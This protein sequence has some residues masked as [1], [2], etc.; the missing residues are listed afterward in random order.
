MQFIEGEI[1]HVYNRGNNNQPIF[2]NRDNYLFFLFKIRKELTPY[3]DIIAYCL[4]PNHF[5]LI[6]S[7]K[8]LE[9]AHRMTSSHPMSKTSMSKNFSTGLAILLRSYTRAL[10]N[11]QHFTGSLFQ[12]KT[13]ARLIENKTCNFTINDLLICMNYVHQNPLKARLVESM[14]AWE[15][16]SYRD[17]ANLRSGTLCNKQLGFELTGLDECEFMKATEQMVE[18]YFSIIDYSLKEVK[19]LRP[20]IRYS[21]E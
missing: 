2:F 12:Q 1:Y 3:C 15:F 9:N 18:D 14:A 19:C 7:I 16:S 11:Q 8:P 10:Q 5:H 21:S 6:V 17:Y 20:D 13:K 4:M